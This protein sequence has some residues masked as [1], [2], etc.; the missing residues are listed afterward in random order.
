VGNAAEC[1]NSIDRP[2]GKWI[3]NGEHQCEPRGPTISLVMETARRGS[4]QKR[5]HIH[6]G[7]TA[8]GGISNERER[9]K[10]GRNL[11]TPSPTHLSLF[12]FHPVEVVNGFLLG[13]TCLAALMPP[14]VE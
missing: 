14:S 2:R 9:G 12:F 13:A 10:G 7:P 11:P 1:R 8:S 6:K 3:P 5:G 4:D